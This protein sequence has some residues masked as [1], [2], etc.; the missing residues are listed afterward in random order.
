[1]QAAQQDSAVFHA[2]ELASSV[3]CCINSHCMRHNAS[4]YDEMLGCSPNH[5][6][7]SSGPLTLMKLAWHSL[8]MAFASSVFPQPAARAYSQVQSR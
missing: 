2:S 6:V 4:T 7:S 5:M 3:C 8:A 1:M